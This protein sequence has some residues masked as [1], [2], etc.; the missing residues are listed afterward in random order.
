MAR[1]D[2]AA[3]QGLRPLVQVPSVRPGT[4][5][6]LATARPGDSLAVRDG[7]SGLALAKSRL[8]Q[9][10]VLLTELKRLTAEQDQPGALADR[11]REIDALIAS[12]DQAAAEVALQRGF[13]HIAVTAVS[14]EV[15][16]HNITE[17]TLDPGESLDLDI[18][19]RQ[20]AQQGA[21]FLSMGGTSIDL[22]GAASS[23]AVEFSGPLGSRELQ[24]SS[25]M[26]LN[27]IATAINSVSR[28]T[29]IEAQASGTG[30]VLRSRELGSGEFVS[31]RI[32]DDGGIEGRDTLGIYTM[33]A[34]D[35]DTADRATGA[36]YNSREAA[37]GIA[38]PGQD[39]IALV[40]GEPV[41][42][43]GAT[44]TFA[45]AHV[46][47]SVTLAT[48]DLTDSEGANAQNLGLLQALT[49]SVLKTAD[50]GGELA[51]APHLPDVD[52][53]RGQVSTRRAFLE[54]L[55]ANGAL[56]LPPTLDAWAGSSG[57]PID[58]SLAAAWAQ[59]A[60]EALL[61]GDRVDGAIDPR[62]VLDLL[63]P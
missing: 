51:T 15:V 6:A 49:V 39:I 62:R 2:T 42:G 48:G 18:F 25:S 57:E 13:D 23:F 54:M 40:D 60:R 31:V 21:L 8:D 34:D 41:H 30:I 52:A 10:D 35:A 5:A 50:D 47:G 63:D 12:I 14:P 4:D 28:D 17:A 7:A 43:T 27:N 44:L 3:L 11:Q 16:F 61:A 20:S 46:A 24:F 55:Q 59:D 36:A 19:V 38:D 53:L 32:L 26:S 22:G 37:R 56:H 33:L 45:T 1:I 29:G 58:Q 9:L